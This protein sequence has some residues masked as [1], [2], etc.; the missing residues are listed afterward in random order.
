M[1]WG[2]SWEVGAQAVAS[3]KVTAGDPGIDTAAAGALALGSTTATSVNIDPPTT[4]D[5][6]LVANSLQLVAGD[7]GLDTTAAGTLAIG[8]TNATQ[9]DVDPD[10]AFSSH[11]ISNQTGAA[12]VASVLGVNITSV[13]FTGNDRRGK[14]V[15]VSAG[16]LAA[17]TRIATCTWL[18]SFG[19]IV[20]LPLLVNQTSGVGLLLV[21]FYSGAEVA[22][23]FDLFSDFALAAGTYTLRYVNEG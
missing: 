17:N 19:A 15:I 23:S 22:A 5:N 6:T 11:L 7:P 18:T 2:S 4:I 8:S 14:I 9:I 10:L 20:P 16:I 13:T 3:L 12:P 1:P 21:N